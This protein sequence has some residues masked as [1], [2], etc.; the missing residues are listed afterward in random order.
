[1]G[2]EES[3]SSFVCRGLI[4]LKPKGGNN[5]NLTTCSLSLLLLKISSVIAKR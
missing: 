2:N 5:L 3:V 4:D 1:M